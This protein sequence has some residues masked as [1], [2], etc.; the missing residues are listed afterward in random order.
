MCFSSYNLRRWKWYGERSSG[1]IWKLCIKHSKFKTI[2]C[3]PSFFQLNLP[4]IGFAPLLNTTYRFHDHNEYVNADVYLKGI[5]IYEKIIPSIA[6]VW[7]PTF[8]IYLKNKINAGLWTNKV[9]HNFIQIHSRA[10]FMCFL[11]LKIHDSFWWLKIQS[12]Q[13]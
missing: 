6:N 13:K 7:Y 12:L 4:A 9:L 3:P 11:I 8:S 2:K 10:F 5:E 1:I